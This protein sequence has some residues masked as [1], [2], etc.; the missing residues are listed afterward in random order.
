MQSNGFFCPNRRKLWRRMSRQNRTYSARNDDFFDFTVRLHDKVW[1]NVFLFW[2][3]TK[4]LIKLSARE[5]NFFRLSTRIHN[6]AMDGHEENILASYSRRGHLTHHPSIS[7][8]TASK[9]ARCTCP[10]DASSFFSSRCGKKRSRIDWTVRKVEDSSL[11]QKDVTGNTHENDTPGVRNDAIFDVSI[12]S[13]AH[14]VPWGGSKMRFNLTMSFL[15]TRK[16]DLR[17]RFR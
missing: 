6:Q 15:F 9:P 14:P 8:L 2:K 5:A 4:K 17:R 3:K 13:T 7:S 16:S 1:P 11:P 10:I 12:R